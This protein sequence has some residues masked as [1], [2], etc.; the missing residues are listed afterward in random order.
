MPQALP[1][2]L[3]HTAG[4]SSRHFPDGLQVHGDHTLGQSR[5]DLP[6]DGALVHARD[7]ESDPDFCREALS[8]LPVAVGQWAQCVFV[9]T[10]PDAA[11]LRRAHPRL[12]PLAAEGGFDTDPERYRLHREA[13]VDIA[14]NWKLWYDKSCTVATAHIRLSA[15]AAEARC[16]RWQRRR[17]SGLSTRPGNPLR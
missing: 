2:R 6:P 9:N 14:A 8:L 1:G 13:V 10:D 7:A 5:L 3:R 12:D 16:T 15:A 11:P 17:A 4:H